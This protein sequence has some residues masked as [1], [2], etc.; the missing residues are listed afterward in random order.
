MTSSLRTFRGR[1]ADVFL[2]QFRHF[3]VENDAVER[4]ALVRTRDLLSHGCQE[5][6]RVEEAGHPETCGTTL[7]EPR[8]ELLVSV[9]QV[10]EPETERGRLPGNLNTI[11]KNHH[12]VKF[13][14]LLSST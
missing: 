7:K 12:K 1:P 3:I 4:P 13:N 6:G 9:E 10:S 5:S 2:H 14:G 8:V 11:S